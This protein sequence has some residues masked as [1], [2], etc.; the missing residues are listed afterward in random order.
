MK[1]KLTIA[2]LGLSVVIIAGIWFYNQ[3]DAVKRQY[4]FKQNQRLL[5][6]I[7][8]LNKVNQRQADSLKRFNPDPL[9]TLFEALDRADE[10]TSFVEYTKKVTAEQ[11][12]RDLLQSAD[13]LL[14]SEP[15]SDDVHGAFVGSDR[16]QYNA[17]HLKKQVNRFRIFN[18]M[19][20]GVTIRELT[21]ITE[22][23]A[24]ESFCETQGY[25]CYV[26]VI[27]SLNELILAIEKYKS[28]LLN[29]EY[30]S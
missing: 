16:E 23:L 5:A 14:L 6:Q 4:E 2:A 8:S 25:P 20:T 1:K 18:E 21:T 15:V 19:Y 22:T 12:H 30:T 11:A 29:D 9:L 10:L 24:N 26:A 27:T 17:K 3:T 13:S 7:D 28:K